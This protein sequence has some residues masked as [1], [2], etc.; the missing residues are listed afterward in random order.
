MKVEVVNGKLQILETKISCGEYECGKYDKILLEVDAK[1]LAK[2][3]KPY[4][5][6]IDNCECKGCKR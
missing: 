5:D 2:A 3:L 6:S 1:E 4:L